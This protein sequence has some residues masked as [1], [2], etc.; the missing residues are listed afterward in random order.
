MGRLVSSWMLCF[1]ITACSFESGEIPTLEVGQAFVDSNVRLV[2]LDTFELRM[3]TFKFD[4]II[5]SESNRLLF[6]K[7]SDDYFGVVEAMA[8]FE[9]IA[10]G[11]ESVDGPY[12]ID[13][14][15]KLDSV[16]LILGY[17]EYFYQDT[18]RLTEINV[19]GLLEEVIPEE[20]AFYNTSTLKYDTVPLT[21]KV[22]TPE[23]FDEDSLYISLPL[24]FGNNLFDK[25]LENEINDNDDLKEDL[26]GFVLVPGENDNASIIGFSRNE[27]DTYLRFFYSVPNEFDDNEEVLDLVIN[28]FPVSPPAFHNVQSYSGG[29][30]LDVLDD[31][32]T[33][34][35]SIESNDLSFIQSGTGF[36]TKVIF[37]SIKSL[38]NIPGTGTLLSARLQIKPQTESI[39][40]FTPLRDS[41]SVAVIDANN[42]IV[43]EIRTGTGPVRGVL[44][45]EEEEFGTV[46]YEIPVGIFLDQKLSEQP[47]T[48]NAL[49]LF[50]ENF[51]ETV[52][53]LVLEGEE[54][55]DYRARLIL[56]YAIYDE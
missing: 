24:Q 42:V 28:P 15:A 45:G 27:E 35:M 41:L 38:F 51:N 14:E 10:P 46:L 53:R 47:E 30:G 4:S 36:A 17:D 55:E 44:I 16:A 21:T 26:P 32:E 31:Q 34:L 25:I 18:T 40:D 23:P 20:N 39:T 37:P 52:N 8:F 29:T 54:N 7:Y 12:D 9:V 13:P 2:V 1:C 22:F 43:Q 33:E 49:I 48:E 6:G 56:T 50:N 19:H 11:M 5:T 3:S